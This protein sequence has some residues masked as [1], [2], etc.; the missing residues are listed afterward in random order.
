MNSCFGLYKCELTYPSKTVDAG[1]Y[2]GERNDCHSRA[3]FD[4]PG[5]VCVAIDIGHR[6]AS[7]GHNAGYDEM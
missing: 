3:A 2:V 1:K 5:K 7:A 6:V 4:L